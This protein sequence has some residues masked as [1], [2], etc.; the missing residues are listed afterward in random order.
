MLFRS[1]WIITNEMFTALLSVQFNVGLTG[2]LLL[3]FV[4][5]EKQKLFYASVAIL[6]GFLVKLYGVVLLAFFFF[7]KQKIKFIGAFAI[8]AV[9]FFFAPLLITDFTFLKTSYIDWFHALIYKSSYNESISDMANISFMG[10]MKKRIGSEHCC[11]P[12]YNK[13]FSNNRIARLGSTVTTST[14]GCIIS[15]LVR[16]IRNFPPRAS[17]FRIPKKLHTWNFIRK[18][19]SIEKAL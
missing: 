3:G 1:A 14:D 4:F 15:S 11:E 9:L 6:I 17:V 7:I 8:V 18:R 12:L 16:A 2:L 10:I 13:P 5:L 19:N